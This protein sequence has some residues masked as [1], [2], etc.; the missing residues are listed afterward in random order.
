M[1]KDIYKMWLK[2]L[3]LLKGKEATLSDVFSS[4]GVGSTLNVDGKNMNDG[5]QPQPKSQKKPAV[6]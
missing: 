4:F 2:N 6:N 1:L 5:S 3:S